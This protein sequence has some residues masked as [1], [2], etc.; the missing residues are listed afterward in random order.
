MEKGSYVCVLETME[1][2][3]V[4][5]VES[6][7]GNQIFYMDDSTSYHKKQISE[8]T[9]LVRQALILKHSKNK[10]MVKNVISYILMSNVTTKY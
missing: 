9:D 1:L 5:E 6:V 7:E 3:T 4:S 2:K 8:D 10:Q